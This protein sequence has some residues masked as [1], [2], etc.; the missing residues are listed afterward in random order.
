MARK[1]I[2]SATYRLQFNSGF[3]FAQAQE[4]LQYLSELGITDIYAS[5]LFK[6]GPGSTHGYDV[7]DFDCLNEAL[8]SSEDFEHLAHELHRLGMGMLLDI[9]PNHMGTDLSNAWWRDVLKHGRNSPYAEWFDIDWEPLKSDLHNKILLPL[10]G[11]H[12]A[13]VLESGELRLAIDQGKFVVAYYDKNFPVS[14]EAAAWAVEQLARIAASQPKLKTAASRLAALRSGAASEDHPVVERLASQADPVPDLELALQEFNRPPGA[15][16]TV[17][18][19]PASPATALPSG[20]LESRARRD[21]LPPFLRCHQSCVSAY[22]IARGVRNHASPR[23]FTRPE[24]HCDR[25]AHRPPGRSVESE[26]NVTGCKRLPYQL[27]VRE[28]NT[29]TRRVFTL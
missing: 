27:A 13:R 8:G 19:L 9:V 21:Q 17:S 23:S 22:G 18:R 4:I 16:E 11:D 14:R 29:L 24:R 20:A 1:H 5:P 26:G 25:T 6:A 12:Y 15:D 10:L 2:P 28:T 3:T 7:C